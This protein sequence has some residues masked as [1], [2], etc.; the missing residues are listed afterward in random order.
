MT[1]AHTTVFLLP[2]I[3]IAP[4]FP[5]AAV[6]QN[7]GPSLYKLYCVKCHGDDGTAKTAAAQKMKVANLRSDE[8][9]KRSDN[10]LFDSISRGTRHKQYP[11][12]FKYRGLSDSQIKTLVAY[13]RELPKTKK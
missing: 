13:I 10:E 2:L 12:A 11:H 6:A 4:T 8:V 5:P 3:V 1:R 9:Q 7:D